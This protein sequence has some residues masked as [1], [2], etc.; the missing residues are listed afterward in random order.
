MKFFNPRHEVRVWCRHHQQ[1]VIWYA[2][3]PDTNTTLSFN[4]EAALKIWLDN[5]DR[6][7][8]PDFVRMGNVAGQNSHPLHLYKGAML[9]AK[10]VGYVEEVPQ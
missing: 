1:R 4:T 9:V 3:N 2:Y 8:S 7:S 10:R 5:Y 6:G